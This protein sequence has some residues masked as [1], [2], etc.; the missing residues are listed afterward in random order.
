MRCHK[1][2]WIDIPD[3]PKHLQGGPTQ[4]CSECGTL[5]MDSITGSMT[6]EHRLDLLWL[7]TRLMC[8]VP[9][10]EEVPDNKRGFVEYGVNMLDEVTRR[11]RAMIDQ[12]RVGT[13]FSEK[14]TEDHS[15]ES[16][17]SL[18]RYVFGWQSPDGSVQARTHEIVESKLAELDRRIPARS[19]DGDV[20]KEVP[21][22]KKVS[23][24]GTD[25]LLTLDELPY[26]KLVELAGESGYPTIAY[27]N[28][29]SGESGT[30]YKGMSITICDGM[31]FTVVH[32]G[33]A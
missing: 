27:H 4:S 28:G 10:P 13:V 11:G 6:R 9:T 2:V 18:L 19:Y 8:Y 29:V 5:N 22:T 31:H 12:L 14:I 21:K 3:I 33:S 23:I 16:T 26:Q 15:R 25:H 24:N 17:S 32:T 7:I 20:V 30:M 1:H